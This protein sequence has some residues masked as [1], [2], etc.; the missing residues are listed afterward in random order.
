VQQSRRST[1]RR[2]RLAVELKVCDAWGHRT[3]SFSALGVI[4]S[5]S[6]DT[7]PAVAGISRALAKLL[8][9]SLLALA[10][11]AVLTGGAE[12]KCTS[13]VLPK[14][15]SIKQGNGYALVFKTKVSKSGKV[16]GTASYHTG[17][18]F[19]LVVGELA[20]GSFDG[21]HLDVRVNWSGGSRG[22]YTA[23]VTDEGKLKGTTHDLSGGPTVNFRSIQALACADA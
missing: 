15:F 5:M 10:G 8:G 17:E 20:N 23:K 12:A 6:T 14:S 22:D 13:W 21:H 19:H 1:N 4:A 16:T 9:T 7:S 18:D 11:V 3:S 2:L